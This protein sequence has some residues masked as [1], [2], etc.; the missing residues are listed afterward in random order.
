MPSLNKSSR[1]R[2]KRLTVL[3]LF[4]YALCLTIPLTAFSRQSA[5]FSFDGLQAVEGAPV[6]RVYINPEADFSVYTRVMI[7]EPI[8][9]FRSDWQ[10]DQNR[11]RVAILMHATCRESRPMSLHFSSRF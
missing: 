6:A 4:I 2:S 10:R 3:S 7:L 9:A 1:E 5:N 8:V 11:R